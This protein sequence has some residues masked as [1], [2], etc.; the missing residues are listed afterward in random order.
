MLDLIQLSK[1]KEANKRIFFSAL[2]LLLYPKEVGE[3][4]GENSCSSSLYL[5]SFQMDFLLPDGIWVISSVLLSIC[6]RHKAL[7]LFLLVLAL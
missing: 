1:Q 2:M 3:A 4:V 6:S 5:L 7:E